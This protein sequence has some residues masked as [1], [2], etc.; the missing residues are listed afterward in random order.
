[1]VLKLWLSA[2]RTRRASAH[3]RLCPLFPL[4]N[5]ER[6]K[7]DPSSSMVIGSLRVERSLKLMSGSGAGEINEK[8]SAGSLRSKVVEG[9]A[10][11]ACHFRFV[12]H[13][14]LARD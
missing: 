11:G 8:F 14:H 6:L 1:M 7:A 13:A 5:P 3:H 4:P 12:W 2:A 9:R 10:S